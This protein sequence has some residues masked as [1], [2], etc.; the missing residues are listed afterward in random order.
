MRRFVLSLAVITGTILGVVPVA[1]AQGDI[2]VRRVGIRGGLT[3]D[4]DQV[5]VGLH[6]NA[7]QFASKVRFQPSFDVGFG[8][9][10]VVGTINID[11][12]Y[13][14]EPRSWAPYLGGGLGVSL[15]HR[16][17]GRKAGGA[18]DFDVGAGLNLI[19]GF[20]WGEASKYL[21]EARVGVGD[22]PDL[23]LTVGIN[24]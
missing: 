21:L 17:S 10:R 18:G 14:F 7:G 19:G 2:G 16:D 24:F 6:V 4:P 1:E 15:T 5:H 3:V 13:T 23:K 22:L 9:N 20:E 11:A 8:S 12:L